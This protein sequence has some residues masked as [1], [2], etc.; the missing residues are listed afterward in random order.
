[1]SS[2]VR[3]LHVDD[4]PGLA[5]M[6][7]TFLERENDRFTIETA[8]RASE[9]LERFTKKDFDCI[10]SDYEMPD[11]NG[12]E[13]LK[14]VRENY[15]QLPFILFTG[16]GSEEIASEA[17]S[18]GVSDYLQK[19]SGTEQYALLANQISNL[20]A[21]YQAE[22]KLETRIRQ[23]EIVADLGQEALEGTALETLF[24]HA[25]TMVA[26]A[27]GNEYAK[28]L[29][30]RPESNDLLLRAGVGW[31]DG[32]V[33]EGTVGDGPDSQAGHTLRS[34]EPIIVDDLRTE[35]R[36][37]G[38]PLLVEH[39]VVSGVSVI[40]GTA[41]NP[42]GVFGTH[43][44][45]RK[46]FT[47][48]DITFV[49]S[50]ANVLASAIERTN[51]EQELQRQNDRLAEF[52]RI[53]SHDLK[54]PLKVARGNLTLARE[55]DDSAHLAD[56]ADALDRSQALIEDLLT[57]SRQ[58]ERVSDVESVSIEETMEVCWQ[59]IETTEATLV[60]ETSRTV[61]ANRSSLRQLLSNLVRNAVE[62]G[63]EDVTVTIGDLEDGFYVADDGP[64]IPETEREI[65]FEAGY[66]TTDEGT[67]FGLNIVEQIA[68]AHGWEIN[69]TGNDSGGTRFAITGA[70]TIST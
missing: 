52:T 47:E 35:D 20:V 41:E 65:V 21:Q 58:G 31:R 36:F 68:N 66:S 51:R 6:V 37:S 4:E 61:R 44:T 55:E 14:R 70:E 29:E 18:A 24:D 2:S 42:W 13:L 40:I 1:M 53:V 15:P 60:T 50:V 10:V 19:D 12:I 27:L 34:E 28:V 67:G 22:A 69:L 7:A 43:T 32:L 17:I 16:K 45:A 5:D 26:E 48:D 23:Q 59:T 11:K 57:L 3:V 30:Y 38:P 9:G 8:Q 39:D 25:V 49:Q 63:A 62:H 46:E 54:S 56:V 33:G 64:G